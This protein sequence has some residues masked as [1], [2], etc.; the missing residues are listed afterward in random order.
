M[1]ATVIYRDGLRSLEALADVL[2]TLMF[3]VC[4]HIYFLYIYVYIYIHIFPD[5]WTPL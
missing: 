3:D 4:E 1:Q 2:D 5:L